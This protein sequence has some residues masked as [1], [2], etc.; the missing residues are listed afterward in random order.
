MK[1]KPIIIGIAGRKQSGKDTVASMINYMMSV[2]LAQADYYTWVKKEFVYKNSNNIIHFADKLKDYCSEIF[3]IHRELFDDA[4]CKD[5]KVWSITHQ[6]FIDRKDLDKDR[7]YELTTEILDQCCLNLMVARNSTNRLTKKST[8][9]SLRTIMQYIGTGIFRNLI[10]KD[11][12]VDMTINKACDIADTGY[13]IIPDVRFENEANAIH[14]SLYGGTII[15]LE[16]D[17]KDNDSHE[18]EIIDFK[19]DKT[20]INNGNKMSLFYKVLL[21]LKEI[22]K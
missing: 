22:I 3:N 2:G 21:T 7:Y 9:I 15:K 6:I 16:R 11:I 14:S 8:V 20:I 10:S 18:S 5:N 1:Y 4:E 19:C 12:W 17:N 13:C